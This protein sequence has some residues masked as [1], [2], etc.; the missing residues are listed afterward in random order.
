MCDF[1]EHGRQNLTK[2]DNFDYNFKGMGSFNGPQLLNGG[3]HPHFFSYQTMHQG[4]DFVHAQYEKIEIYFENMTIKIVT[5]I[6]I[7]FQNL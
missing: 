5:N 7:Y 6:S 3:T 2:R 4:I 1:R